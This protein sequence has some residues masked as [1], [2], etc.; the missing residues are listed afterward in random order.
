MYYRIC[1]NCGAYLDPGERCDCLDNER[2][3]PV[4][5]HRGAAVNGLQTNDG[6]TVTRQSVTIDSLSRCWNTR[7]ER[8]KA[9]PVLEHRGG[10][11]KCG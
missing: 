5:E 6:Y 9:T 1:N 10:K 7:T 3:A 11:V 8:K 2:T 4:L